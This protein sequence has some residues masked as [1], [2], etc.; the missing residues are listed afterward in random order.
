MLGVMNATEILFKSFIWTVDRFRSG[1]TAMTPS[2][3]LMR[4]IQARSI[5]RI[6]VISQVL[7]SRE[8]SYPRHSKRC[9]VKDIAPLYR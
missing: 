8:R 5:V 4:S 9:G 3:T 1:H 6:E 7:F 2:E